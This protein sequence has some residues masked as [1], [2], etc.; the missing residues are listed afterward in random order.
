MKRKV[1]IK[2]QFDPLGK[3]RDCVIDKT[4]ERVARTLRVELENFDPSYEA[5]MVKVMLQNPRSCETN[6]FQTFW[7]QFYTEPEDFEDPDYCA[8]R[9]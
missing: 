6:K 3:R 8:W 5:L 1:V 4:I 9:P 2:T 7:V